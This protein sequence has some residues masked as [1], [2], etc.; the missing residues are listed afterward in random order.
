[1]RQ[2]QGTEDQKL[3]ATDRSSAQWNWETQG[4]AGNLVLVEV[5]MTQGV[6]QV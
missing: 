5:L 6:T 1:M 4:G 2:G 3:E